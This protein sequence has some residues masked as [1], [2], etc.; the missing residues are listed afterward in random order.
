[1]RTYLHSLFRRPPYRQIFRNML[2]FRSGYLRKQ[3]Y[4]PP[5]SSS[6]E[7]EGWGAGRG[8]CSA[9]SH[10]RDK[11]HLFACFQVRGSMVPRLH[12]GCLCV[13]LGAPLTVFSSL[14][15]F[16]S[17]SWPQSPRRIN[18]DP[19]SLPYQPPSA[20]LSSPFPPLLS[21]FI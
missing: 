14:A 1:M 6:A 4:P 17:V 9:A 11:V 20:Q 10:C 16:G 7:T 19:L 21:K 12:S 5:R 3:H 15:L 18:K 8:A 13:F 2:P